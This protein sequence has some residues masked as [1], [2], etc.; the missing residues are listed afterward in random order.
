MSRFRISLQKQN[1]VIVI[2]LVFSQYLPVKIWNF[3][4]QL[5]FLRPSQFIPYNRPERRL[6]ATNVDYKSST[7]AAE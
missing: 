5:H 2:L 3:M 1:T 7:E 4:S 6:P